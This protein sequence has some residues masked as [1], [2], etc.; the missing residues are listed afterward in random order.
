MP[1]P[2]NTIP[3]PGLEWPPQQYIYQVVELEPSM[4]KLPP[5][6]FGV[7][8]EAKLEE[9]KLTL[10]DIWSRHIIEWAVERYVEAHR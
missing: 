8:L 6:Q 7:L 5:K 3:L 4:L 10:E 2:T 9:A 1:T